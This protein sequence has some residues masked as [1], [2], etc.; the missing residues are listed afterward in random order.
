MTPGRETYLGDGVYVSLDPS[1]MVYL[2]APR[3]HGDHWIGLEPEVLHALLFW[4]ESN[5]IIERRGSPK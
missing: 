2:R 4:L 1:R 3:S 5:R